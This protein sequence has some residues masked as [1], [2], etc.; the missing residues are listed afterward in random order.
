LSNDFPRPPI[1]SAIP[2][3]LFF[4]H[5]VGVVIPPLKIK[6]GRGG[7]MKILDRFRRNEG[8][9]DIQ[10]LDA[11]TGGESNP[12]SPP[13]YKGEGSRNYHGNAGR[14]LIFS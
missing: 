9:L 13:L 4:W 3:F 8:L 14:T 1:D 2:Q 12:S 11:A 10:S 7:V 5:F 6:R